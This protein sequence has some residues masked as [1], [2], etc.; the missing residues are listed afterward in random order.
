M[1]STVEIPVSSG[2]GGCEKEQ[3]PHAE[4]YSL[5]FKSEGWVECFLRDRF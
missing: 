3:S 2:P 4:E 1:R 5:G